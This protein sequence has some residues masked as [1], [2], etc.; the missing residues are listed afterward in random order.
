[1]LIERFQKLK[2]D[3]LANEFSYGKYWESAKTT[4]EIDFNE[5]GYQNLGSRDYFPKLFDKNINLDHH[6]ILDK[7]ENLKVIEIGSRSFVLEKEGYTNDT[8]LYSLDH[9]R[10]ISNKINTNDTV[11]EVGAGSGILTGLIHNT[12]KTKNIII[13]IP[14][15]ILC[16][17]SFLFTVFPDKNFLLPNEIDDNLKIKDYDFIFLTP[18]QKNLIIDEEIDLGIN[19]FSFMEMDY[20][21]IEEYLRFFQKKIK[22]EKF[23]FTSNRIRKVNK[24]FK[25]PFDLLINF[26]KIYIQR[27][28]YLYIK[29]TTVIDLL[30]QKDSNK[31]FKFIDLGFFHIYMNIFLYNPKELFFWFKKDILYLISKFLKIF[32]KK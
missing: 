30:V 7:K 28:N 13:D 24:F 20:Q 17:I 22:H 5:N 31:K 18:D 6:Q 15:V 12:K 10:K 2:K 3:L 16:S 21:E 29:G 26:K 23:F 19:T 9:L 14:N 4:F 27:N 1:M 25:Y 32:K 11:C 8:L